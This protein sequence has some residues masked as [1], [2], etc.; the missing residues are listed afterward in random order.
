MGLLVLDGVALFLIARKMEINRPWLSFIPIVN[1]WVVEAAAEHRPTYS[2][3]GGPLL[4]FFGPVWYGKWGLISENLGHSRRLGYLAGFPFI[5]LVPMWMLALKATP[6]GVD[7]S[8]KHAWERGAE[9]RY[10]RTLS[11]SAAG[12][13]QIPRD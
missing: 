10:R 7:V 3:G 12:G 6:D 5:G 4:L 2:P 11:S 1:F 13:R 8:A 9:A